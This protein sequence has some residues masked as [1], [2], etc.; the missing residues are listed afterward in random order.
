MK[1]SSVPLVAYVV[2]LWNNKSLIDQCVESILAQEYAKKQVILVDNN[3]SDDSVA[4]I[5]ERYPDVTLVESNVNTGFTGGNNLGIKEALQRSNTKYVALINSDATLESNWTTTLVEFMETKHNVAMTQ[6]T[7]FDFYDHEIVDSYYIYVARNSQATQ[8]GWRD[9]YQGEVPVK[10]VFGVNAAACL[11]SRSFIES[12]P[13]ANTGFFDE[14]FFMYLEDVDIAARATVTGWANYI[15]PNAHAFH[16]GSASS[17]KNPNFSLYFTFRNNSAMIY[18]NF[19]WKIIFRLLLQ[20]IR[21]DYHTFRHLRR[22][23][24]KESSWVIY[25][26][27]LAGLLRLPI[28]YRDRKIMKAA[29]TVDDDYLWQLM[30]KVH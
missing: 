26:A 6:G 21:S 12:Q 16:M 7:T 24:R 27:R 5:K 28:Y 20:M 2:V 10:R 25:K 11:I 15:V 22:I 14:K 17:S 1:S 23:G 13:F 9:R 29:R 19:S 18:K 3:S 30:R 8:A 4:Y